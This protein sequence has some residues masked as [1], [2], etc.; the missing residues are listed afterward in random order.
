VYLLTK[1]YS[2]FGKQLSL[3]S[4]KHGLGIRDPEKTYPG[5]RGQTSTESWI[6]IRNTGVAG[7]TFRIRISSLYTKDYQ[8][9]SEGIVDLSNF[10]TVYKIYFTFNSFG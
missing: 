6:R 8:Q 9:K 4:Q 7:S 1:N 2:T 3:T 10:L 5:F